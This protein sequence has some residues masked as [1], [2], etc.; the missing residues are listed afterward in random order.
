M[1]N[2]IN[3][4]NQSHVSVSHAVMLML[5]LSVFYVCLVSDV[6]RESSASAV[7]MVEGG[8]RSSVTSDRSLSIT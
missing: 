3:T 6:S 1:V 2:I 4:T 8:G 7:D 5:L